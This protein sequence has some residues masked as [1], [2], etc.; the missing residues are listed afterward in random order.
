M[1]GTSVVHYGKK[2]WIWGWVDRHQTG[3]SSL[4]PP[5]QKHADRW[6]LKLT[7]HNTDNRPETQLSCSVWARK[8]FRC[9]GNRRPQASRKEREKGKKDRPLKRISKA[10]THDATN[11]T[12]SLYAE[13]PIRKFSIFLN[14]ATTSDTVPYVR[15]LQQTQVHYCI[16]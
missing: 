15:R 16:F 11:P 4:L 7:I 3:Y 13:F 9:Q 8:F 12:V 5:K 6:H 2:V 1:V 10:P 14:L